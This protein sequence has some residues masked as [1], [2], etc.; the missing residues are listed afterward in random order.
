MKFQSLT[1]VLAIASWASAAQA[2]GLPA[3]TVTHISTFNFSV[4]PTI[5]IGVTPTVHRVVVPI[6]G[7]DFKGP[8]LSGTILPIGGDWGSIDT[9]GKF[10][11]NA[12][13]NLK[14]DDGADIYGQAQGTQ[15]AAEGPAYSNVV[16]ETSSKDYFYLNSAFVLG[17]SVV[18]TT[19]TYI[20]I[21]MYSV[22]V[23]LLL[24]LLPV[25]VT[26]RGSA[27]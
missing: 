22:S 10:R 4:A 17:V 19:G 12:R 8:K 9:E 7:G 15:Q 21:E 16:L 24:L 23:L 26:C 11:L 3:P 27:R 18:S 2:Q 1:S 25:M 20:I 6:T 5:E 14:T 13:F